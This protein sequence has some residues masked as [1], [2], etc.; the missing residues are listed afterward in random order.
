MRPT[1]N[2]R[3]LKGVGEKRAEL[4]RQLGVRDVGTLLSLYPRDYKDLSHPRT[5]LEAPFDRPCAVK[6]KVTSGIKEQYIRKNMILYKF[7][8]SDKETDAVITLFNSRFVAESLEVDKEYI[9]WGLVERTLL[10]C[11]MSAPEIYETSEQRIIPV[12]PQTAGLNSKAIG[13]IIAGALSACELE[14]PMPQRILESFGLCDYKTALHNIHNPRTKA[15]ITKARNRLCFDELFFLQLGILLQKSTRTKETKIKITDRYLNEFLSLLPFTLTDA[16]KR[17]ITESLQDMQSGKPMSRLVQ[18]DVGSGKTMVAAAL[19]YCAAKE[20]FQ[21]VIMAPT[22]VLATQHYTTLQK[23]FEPQGLKLAL[24]TGSVTKSK[25]NKLKTALKSGDIDLVIGTHAV[26]EDNVEFKNLGLVVTDEQHRFGV[27]QRTKL[28]VKG[29]HPH[30]L[31]M[32]ATPIPRT[33]SLIFYGDLDIS[34]IDTLPNG[35]QPIETFFI[36]GKK[37][38]RAFNYVKKHLDEGRQG[39]IICP[40][41]EENETV[42]LASAVEY[43][44][45]LQAE[46]FKDYSVGLLHGKMKPKEKQQVMTDFKEGKIQ[47]LVSTTVVE[48]GVDVPNAVIMLIENAE[49]FGLSQLH[50]LRGRIGRGQHKSTCILVSD[51]SHGDT[52]ARLKFITSTTDGFKIADEDLKLRGPGDFLGKRQHGLPE[53]KIADL[54]EDM[55]IFRAA[56]KAAKEIYLNDPYLELPENRVLRKPVERLFETTRQFGCN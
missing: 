20:G 16:Q 36:D 53:L 46:D 37:R 41:V 26:I 50:Q 30:I 52:A 40:M 13:K 35:R 27:E 45:K 12:Y 8:A 54:T 2:V 1:D 11:S 4:F 9:F 56:G 14:E 39:Y 19:C 24:L 34:I 31:V 15:D 5:L 32:S 3:F 49:R 25:K 10:G 21:S 6:L 47:L 29:E 42:D 7:L 23:L 55:D 17:A 38:Q 48:V 33:M 44:A 22:E 43:H 28:S 51:Y 18:G